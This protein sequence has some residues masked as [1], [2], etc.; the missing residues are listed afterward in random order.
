[1]KQVKETHGFLGYTGSEY[2]VF[3]KYAWRAVIGFS[4][5]YCFL[6]SG[7]LNLSSAIPMMVKETNWTTGQLGILSSVFFLDVWLGAISKW[8]IK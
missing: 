8:T 3:R 7:R 5:V 4:L 1:M 2:A 6:Y